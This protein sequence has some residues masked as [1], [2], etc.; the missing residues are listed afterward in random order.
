MTGSRCQGLQQG[1]LRQMWSSSSPAGTGPTRSSQITRWTNLLTAW[2]PQLTRP[3]PSLLREP[4]HSQQVPTIAILFL[5]L[6]G[7]SLGWRGPYKGRAIQSLPLMPVN[8]PL[9]YRAVHCRPELRYTWSPCTVHI[10]SGQRA[11]GPDRKKAPPRGSP[12]AGSRSRWPLLP[13]E[14]CHSPPAE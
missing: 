13:K 2:P 7:S 3:Y 5:I 4:C 6:A 10:G 1:G 12:L 11:T 14:N 9:E 8:I